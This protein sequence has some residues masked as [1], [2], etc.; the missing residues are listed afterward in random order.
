MFLRVLEYYQGILF[1]TTNRIAAFDEAFKSRIHIQ[2][3][4][5]KLYLKPSLQVWKS[6]LERLENGKADFKFAL[7]ID[8][9]G[10]LKFAEENY[11][12]LKWN[13]RQIRNAIQTAMALAEYDA[14][15]DQSHST[16]DQKPQDLGSRERRKVR[17]TIDE[18]DKVAK[19]SSGFDEYLRSV[20]GHDDSQAAKLLSLRNDNFRVGNDQPRHPQPALQPPEEIEYSEDETLNDPVKL[21][22]E[23]KRIEKQKRLEKKLEKEKEEQAK[24]DALKRQLD[25]IEAKT[26]VKEEKK[27]R[28]LEEK[29]AKDGNASSTVSSDEDE[30]E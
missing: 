6:N 9:D 30:M 2:L 14:Y 11:G 16:P 28:K 19:A 12:K 3:Y 21:E 5:P 10:I 4:Y 15:L 29:R 18:F 27:R 13:G 24:K 25:E 8:K 26:K 20:R 23:R 7:E 1:L 17:L 22:E